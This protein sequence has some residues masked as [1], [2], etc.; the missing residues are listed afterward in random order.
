MSITKNHEFHF[1]TVLDDPQ[2][3][4]SKNETIE[5]RS[6]MR[7]YVRTSRPDQPV[8]KTNP[9]VPPNWK[10]LLAKLILLLKDNRFGH[11]SSSLISP[12]VDRTTALHLQIGRSGKPVLTNRWRP[13]IGSSESSMCGFFFVIVTQHVEKKWSQLR[14]KITFQLYPLHHWNILWPSKT[15]SVTSR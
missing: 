9:C 7:T 2:V 6:V 14:P 5:A 10:L 13:L 8:R 12:S 4:G 3:L 15:I 11:R 1:V